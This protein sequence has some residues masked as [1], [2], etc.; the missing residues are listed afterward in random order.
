MDEESKFFC[1]TDCKHSANFK[2]K[3]SNDPMMDHIQE[4]SHVICYRGLLIM[5]HRDAIRYYFLS[6]QS[7]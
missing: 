7:P 1:S 5:L 6:Y 2:A 4:Y 3:T